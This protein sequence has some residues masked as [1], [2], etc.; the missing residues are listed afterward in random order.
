ML[1][2]NPEDGRTEVCTSWD[3]YLSVGFDRRDA[4]TSE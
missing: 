3:A 4:Y 2:D 1:L